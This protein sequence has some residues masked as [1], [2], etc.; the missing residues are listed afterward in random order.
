MSKMVVV[1]SCK[2]YYLKIHIIVHMNLSYL[3]F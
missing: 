2:N 3:I 1:T